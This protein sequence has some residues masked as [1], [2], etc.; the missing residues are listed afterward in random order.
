MVCVCVCVQVR[1]QLCGVG[2]V[3]SPL[4]GFP[5]RSSTLRLM[6]R[7]PGSS[8]LLFGLQLYF[9]VKI[10]CQVIDAQYSAVTASNSRTI[11]SSKKKKNL[12]P[13]SS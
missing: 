1:G 4:Y 2:F 5:G 8:S 7:A 10:L 6:Q 12:T 13:V 11:P 9:N 3:L